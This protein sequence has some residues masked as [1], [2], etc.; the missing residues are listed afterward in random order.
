MMIGALACAAALGPNFTPRRTRPM[1][2]SGDVRAASPGWPWMAFDAWMCQD[3]MQN[4]RAELKENRRQRDYEEHKQLRYKWYAQQ[5]EARELGAAMGLEYQVD[6]MDPSIEDCEDEGAFVTVGHR[7]RSGENIRRR[8]SDIGRDALLVA[9]RP[10]LH[11]AEALVLV[12]QRAQHL[13]DLVLDPE[14]V[15]GHPHGHHAGGASGQR[16]CAAQRGSPRRL[17]RAPQHREAIRSWPQGYAE[18]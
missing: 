13:P 12:L 18:W 3:G 16:R 10:A 15:R 4:L 14:L 5:Q 6:M 17:S 11:G 2:R 1:T 7:P 8:G 9:A